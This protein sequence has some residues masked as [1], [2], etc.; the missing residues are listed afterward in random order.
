MFL[1]E[2]CYVLDTLFSMTSHFILPPEVSVNQH[3]LFP[4][5]LF[6]F[7]FIMSMKL[8]MGRYVV[9][10]SLLDNESL[11]VKSYAFDG[12]F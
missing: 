12:C 8:V 1:I 3:V 10:Q 6:C 11:I 5:V 2:N 9:D 7:C 4:V